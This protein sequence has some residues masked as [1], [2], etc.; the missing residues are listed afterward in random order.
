MY[1]ARE[2]TDSGAIGSVWKVGR[3]PLCGELNTYRAADVGGLAARCSSCACPM[4]IPAALLAQDADV[5]A[6]SR[7]P[8]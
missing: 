7:Q 2:T 8:L 1:A 3:C 5:A 4:E 6:N